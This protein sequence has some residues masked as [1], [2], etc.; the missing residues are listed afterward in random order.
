MT[1]VDPQTLSILQNPAVIAIN[2]DPASS[3]AIRRWREYLDDDIDEYGKK[4]ELQLYS[5]SL[6]GGDQV[7]LLLNAGS[8]TREMNASL[9]EI[10][11]DDGVKGTAAQAASSWDIYDLWA[12]RMSNQT[13]S[14][15]INGKVG[16]VTTSSSGYFNA[17]AHGGA[18]KV[19]L[20]PPSSSSKLLMGSKIGSVGPRGTVSATV[21]PHGVAMY[22]LREQKHDEL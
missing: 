19:Y 10:F 18:E 8:K 15:I 9:A 5:G 20:N 17:T 14:A 12:N 6:S 22:R 3:P 2:Q 7:V 11:W 21:R 13:A 1:Q 4:G 16:N